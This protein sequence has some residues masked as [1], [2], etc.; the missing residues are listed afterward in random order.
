MLGNTG[1]YAA[2]KRKK[3]VQKIPK[4][5]RLDGIKSNPSKR[6]RD[7]LNG[8]L[9]KLTSLLPFSEDVR[10]R[11]DKLSVL[12]LSVGFLKVKSFFNATLQKST[13]WL[14][15]RTAAFGGKTVPA[16]DGVAFS[17]GDL[18]LQALNGFVLVVTAEGYIF[19][20]SP[21]IQDYLGFHQLDVVHQSVF[22][23]IHM[24][25]RAM[26]RS[27]LHFALNPTQA[28]PEQCRSDMQSSSQISSNIV[29]Y[30]PQLIPPENSSFLERSFCCRFRCLLDNSSGFLALNF[31]GRLKYLHGQNQ[32]SA[33]GTAAH[34]QLALFA[35]ATPLAD[36]FHPRDPEQDPHL[37]DQT[38]AGLLSNGH[39]YQRKGG[40]GIL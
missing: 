7:R 35:I 20:A 4:P 32:L 26:F 33:D 25:D 40:S 6:H 18:L 39:R 16:I 23:L 31:Q 14:A 3:P 5:L 22:E 12:R 28:D 24:D 13:S 15:E 10:A 38:Q 9:D 8:E 29:T 37:P 27:Q 21:T 11:L 2:K 17:E 30:D 1:G 34:S 36:S 19:Y